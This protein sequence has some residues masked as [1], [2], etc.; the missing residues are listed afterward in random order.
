MLSWYKKTY[1]KTS[2]CIRVVKFE[3]MP[4]LPPISNRDS[5]AYVVRDIAEYPNNPY[6]NQWRSAIN[7]LI[8]K[9]I[10]SGYDGL[11]RAGKAMHHII[12]ST[13]DHH[14]LRQEPRVT[15]E[16]NNDWSIQVHYSTTNVEFNPSIQSSKATTDEA[17]QVL[18]RY[19]LRLW[20]D[21]ITEPVPEALIGRTV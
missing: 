16:V 11:F 21:T 10:R 20:T 5:W 3:K 17:F 9:A 18:T 14:G 8:D 15:V 19:L 2:D 7:P 1:A 12:F 13:I 6:W 4:Q